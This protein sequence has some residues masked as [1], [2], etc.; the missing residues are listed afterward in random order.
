MNI[1]FWSMSS[2][3]SATSGNMLAVSTMASLVYSIKGLLIQLDCCSRPIDDVFEG[4]RQ[5]NLLMEEYA[6]YSKKGMDQLVDLSQLGDL[7]IADLL[8]NAVPV[9]NTN[10]SYIPVLKRANKGVESRDIITC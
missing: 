6:Y 9:K 8:D 5:T 2:G 1:V 4:K 10:I 7:N 3:R